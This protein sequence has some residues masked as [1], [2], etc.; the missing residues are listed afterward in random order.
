VIRLGK[1]P[2]QRDDNSSDDGGAR[3]M[4][5][6][7]DLL[8]PTN[9]RERA[10]SSGTGTNQSAI[11]L[12]VVDGAGQPPMDDNN[13]NRE[14]GPNRGNFA[15][16]L[17]VNASILV[18]T[19]AHVV[20][21]TC[22]FTYRIIVVSSQSK[23][24]ASYAEWTKCAFDN[25]DGSHP[26]AWIET[27]GELPK[28]HLSFGI[29]VLA[30]VGYC[31]Y[32]ALVSAMHFSSM[33]RQALDSDFMWDV[34]DCVLMVLDYMG[35]GFCLEYFDL[36]DDDYYSSAPQGMSQIRSARSSRMDRL[37]S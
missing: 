34:Y 1:A 10:G 16:L 12:P 17:R 22:I 21:M 14:K 4:A 28:Y 7:Q 25:F 9:I 36:N 11:I 5:P 18:F 19:V 31:C 3:A 23:T 35:C 13:G 33:V 37:M 8:F 26:D 6:M 20:L 2:S 24:R 27:C 32:G 30:I 29:T 15:S